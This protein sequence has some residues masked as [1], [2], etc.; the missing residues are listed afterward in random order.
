MSPTFRFLASPH[1]NNRPEDEKITLLVVHAISLPPHRFGGGYVD[2]LFLGRLDPTV[3]PFFKEI[4]GLRVSA[5]FLI[6]REGVVTQYVPVFKRAWHAGVSSWKGRSGC[7]DFSVGIE[8]EGDEKTP[9]TDI[10]YA[11]L[12][13]LTRQLQSGLPDLD[14]EDITGHQDI[15]PKRK[16]DPG[17]CFDWPRFR[18]ALANCGE[19][20]SF[21]SGTWPI[22]WT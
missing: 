10:Q 11:C 8:L 15:A 2:D 20:G 21:S 13:A 22:V 17:P 5:H 18:L 19:S 6:D 9:F 4:E 3:D 1:F 7:N 14:D 12:T 16:W